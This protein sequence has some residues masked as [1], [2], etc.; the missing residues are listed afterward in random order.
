MFASGERRHGRSEMERG[1]KLGVVRRGDKPTRSKLWT[2]QAALELYEPR[3]NVHCCCLLEHQVC[4]HAKR[5]MRMKVIF[6]IVHQI[7][8]ILVSG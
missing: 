3:Y 2:P 8:I 1:W 5:S 4:I 6:L 7:Y